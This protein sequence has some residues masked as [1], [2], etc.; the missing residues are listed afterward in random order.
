M[1]YALYILLV[2]I[3]LF[4]GY[5]TYPL[6]NPVGSDTTMIGRDT[7]LI[8]DTITKEPDPSVI[9]AK[10]ESLYIDSINNLPMYK[11][12]TFD[13]INKYVEL[14][15]MDS[16]EPLGYYKNGRFVKQGSL[17]SWYLGEPVDDFALFWDPKPPEIETITMTK[18]VFK[19]KE[20]GF[21]DNK[22]I[23]FTIGVAAGIGAAKALE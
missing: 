14:H 17:M 22:Y 18:V 8:R 19:E 9:N 15:K 3:F 21:F 13:T 20:I 7:T 10:V 23:N 12:T 11:D 4:V 6:I 2:L 1:R 5:Q 16:A